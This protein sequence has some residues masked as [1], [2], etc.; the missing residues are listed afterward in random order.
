MHQPYFVDLDEHNDLD[1]LTK[2]HPLAALAKCIVRARANTRADSLPR[3]LADSSQRPAA[4]P[5]T[6]V[7]AARRDTM[8]SALRAHLFLGM[9]AATSKVTQG[10]YAT[11]ARSPT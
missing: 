8:V 2:R 11:P 9:G 1:R 6:R 5:H 7:T 10:G 4:P 3:R